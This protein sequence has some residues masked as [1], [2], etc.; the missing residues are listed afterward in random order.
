[1]ELPMS[2]RHAAEQTRSDVFDLDGTLKRL[3]DDRGLLADLIQLFAED[4]PHYLA[5]MEEGLVASQAG[6]IRHAAH[7]LRG[8]AAN[9]GAARLTTTLFEVEQKCDEG[10]IVDVP[11]LV[12]QA[13]RQAAELRTAL[14]P[15]SNHADGGTP[16]RPA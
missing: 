16:L 8:L 15:F 5:R 12:E 6:Q 9:F 7:A 11:K 3:G 14:A 13:K 4:S 2:T 10:L 1:M